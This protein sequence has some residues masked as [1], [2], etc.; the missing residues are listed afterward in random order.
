M[1]LPRLTPTEA[2]RLAEP[3]ARL[4]DIRVRDEFARS[5]VPGAVNRP[6][7][8]L[9]PLEDDA[10]VVFL[11]RSGMRTAGNAARL[12]DCCTGKA[13]ILEGGIDAWKAAGRFGS[14]LRTTEMIS[15][16]YFSGLVPA[17][18]DIA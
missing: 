10:P 5:R 2:K 17:K 8:E 6:I 1:T 9:G 3:G 13:Y 18:V 12:A 11:C 7:D 16:A 14:M 15:I 4:I